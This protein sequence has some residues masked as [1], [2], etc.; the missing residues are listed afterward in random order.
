MNEL[1]EVQIIE[2]HGQPAFAVIPWDEFEA[3]EP[4]LKRHRALRDGI[5]HAV[6]ER[7]ALED[8]H[9]VRAWR[10]H[11]GMEQSAVAAR[12]GM[13]QPALARIE[14]GAGGKTREDTLTRLAKA[15]GLT[16]AQIDLCD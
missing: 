2:Q 8:V 1:T 5:P 4:T 16:I 14:S 12:A 3:I 13:K 11:L 15:M 9:P 6:V 10:E 7:I